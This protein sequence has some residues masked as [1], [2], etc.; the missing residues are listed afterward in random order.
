MPCE[1]AKPG[2]VGNGALL[3]TPLEPLDRL[4][5]LA[6]ALLRRAGANSR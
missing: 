6:T 5:A 3:L 1:G 4:A 2:P